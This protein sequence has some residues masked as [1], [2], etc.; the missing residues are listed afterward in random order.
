MKPRQIS[1]EWVLEVMRQPLEDKAVTIS[2]AAGTLT[3]PSRFMLVA[4]M[5]PCR[6]S[7]YGDLMNECTGSPS[8]MTHNRPTLVSASLR[9]L[10]PAGR[11]SPCRG[12]KTP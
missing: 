3:F 2:R 11:R 6:C 8:I 7:C 4:A 1:S 9:A 10:S 12:A 5:N